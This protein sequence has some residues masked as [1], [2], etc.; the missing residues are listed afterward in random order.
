LLKILSGNI[1]KLISKSGC[2]FDAGIKLTNNY[3]LW[4]KKKLKYYLNVKIKYAQSMNRQCTPIIC[5]CQIIQ[6]SIK[7]K[8]YAVALGILILAGVITLKV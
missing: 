1:T 2:L 5:S 8:M 3:A 7:V 4:L 6:R